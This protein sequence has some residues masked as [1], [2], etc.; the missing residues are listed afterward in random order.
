LNRTGI[1]IVVFVALVGFAV[2]GDVKGWFETPLRLGTDEQG[3][4]RNQIERL[5]AK[6]RQSCRFG[7]ALV[8]AQVREGRKVRA[9]RMA[10]SYVEALAG[11]DQDESELVR[12][13]CLKG[14]ELGFQ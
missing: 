11:L 8:R 9:Q 13:A 6:A 1:A 10:D 3:T 12:R 4:Q 7:A 2:T 5:A 14:L